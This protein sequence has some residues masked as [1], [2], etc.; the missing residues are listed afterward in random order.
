MLHV[1]SGLVLRWL[2]TPGCGPKP[3]ESAGYWGRLPYN[4]FLS[5]AGG[6]SLSP[7]DLTGLLF[8]AR[9]TLPFADFL[10]IGSHQPIAVIHFL[11]DLDKKATILLLVL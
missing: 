10:G 8:K 6:A 2:N 11:K 9:G 7:E 3:S 1:L 4:I 5:I